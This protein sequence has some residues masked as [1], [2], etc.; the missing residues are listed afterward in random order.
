MRTF[1]NAGKKLI[2]LLAVGA[3]VTTAVIN[4]SSPKAHANV[5]TNGDVKVT[6]KANEKIQE[7]DGWGLSEDKKNLSKIYTER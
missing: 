4:G 6:I 7:V 5:E 2:G 3:I 1:K